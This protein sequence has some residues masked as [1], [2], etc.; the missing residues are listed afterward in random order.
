MSAASLLGLAS[1]EVIA[2]VALAVL[3]ASVQGAMGFGMGMLTSSALKLIDHGFVP[4]AILISVIPLSAGVAWRERARID[5]K[6][7]TWSL[8]GRL[9]GIVLASVALS[10]LSERGLSIAIASAVLIAVALSLT[11]LRIQPTNPNLGVAGL[12]SG[13][14]GTVTS[15]GG[16]PMAI[17]Y[18]HGDARIR[19]A[20]LAAYFG[21]GSV[22]SVIVLSV[23][24]DLGARQW[25]LSLILLP[26]VLAGIV[27][28]RWLIRVTEQRLARPLILAM[29]TVSALIL[30]AQQ[31]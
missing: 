3:G 19:Q 17:A 13:F 29:S 22:L 24:G 11:R 15:V 18:Q 10:S 14:M 21:V 6:A 2:C 30:L 4:G 27:L 23:G 9:P 20:T 1:W 5:W 26:G 16:P 8:G 28:S 31:L 12:A 7:F 25:K